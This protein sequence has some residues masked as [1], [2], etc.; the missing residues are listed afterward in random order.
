M[1]GLSRTTILTLG[2]LTAMSFQS[3]V[4]NAAEEA[5]V[6][7]AG[8]Q[9]A[10]PQAIKIGYVDFN[11]VKNE[12]KAGSE[13]Q[14]AGSAMIKEKQDRFQKMQDDL[15]KLIDEAEKLNSERKSSLLSPEAAK[16]K[17]ELL[18][19]KRDRIE[20]DGKALQRFKADA[21]EEVE[22]KGIEVSKQFTEDLVTVINKFGKEEGYTLILDRAAV[23]YA[24]EAVDVTDRI[25]KAFN[26]MKG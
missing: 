10:A 22:K 23:L 1:K 17:E 20:K 4:A 5:A 21:E 16:K 14:K 18:K 15:A 6:P 12:S 11:R 13:A 26:E 25:I 24:P 3:I 19:Q 8:T 9:V 2:F 7:A